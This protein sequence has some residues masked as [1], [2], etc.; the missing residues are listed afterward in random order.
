[1]NEI[2]IFAL[3]E[4]L[5]IQMKKQGLYYDTTN[6]IIFLIFKKNVIQLSSNHR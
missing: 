2:Q 1:M 6:P 4:N 3:N 5:N